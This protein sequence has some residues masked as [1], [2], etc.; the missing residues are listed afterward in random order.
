M[1][2]LSIFFISALAACSPDG[3]ARF[4]VRES[5]EQL[6]VTHATPGQVLTLFDHGG[7]I[8]ASGTADDQGSLMFRKV[9]PADGYVIWS[10]AERSRH[11]SVISVALSQPP[12]S[13]YWQQ[14]LTA[15]LNYIKT[16]DGTTLS[17]YVTLPGPVEMGP[18]PTVVTYS[19]YDPSRPPDMGDNPYA[20][21]CDSIP[22]LCDRPS[23]PS[24]LI[25]AVWGYA[26]V[27]V[28]IR[29]TGCSGGAYDYFE[30]LQLLDGYDV[31]ETVAA[32]EWVQGH[33]VGLVGLSYPGITQLFVA[34]TNPPHLA[35]IT[36]LSVIGNSETT[37]L[38]GGI[39]NDGFAIDWVHY[40]LDGAKPYGQGWE[41]P[42]VDAGDHECA[43]NQL[44]HAQAIDNVQQARTTKFY[45]PALHDRYNPTTFVNKIQVPVF[46]AGAWQDEQTGPFFFTLL[47]KFTSSPTT[48]FHVY[49]GVHPDGFQPTVLSEW[50]SFL[51]LFVADRVPFDDSLQRQLS[52]LLYDQIYKAKVRIPPSRWTN[53][54]NVDAAIA[55]WKAAPTLRA[56][57]ESGAGQASL[58]GAPEPTFVH[59]FAS[60]PPPEQT[61]ERWYLHAD[62]GLQQA[63]PTET[64]AS[65][66][67][68]L[69][70]GAGERGIMAPGGNI[71]D[72]LPAYNW[73]Q[74]QPGKAVVFESAP[75]QSEEV[76]LGPA[77]F[78]LWLTSS[79]VD[80]DLQVNLSEV[81]PDGKE[82]YI[83]SGW[84]RASYRAPSGD[85]TAFYPAPSF[86]EADWQPLVPGQWTQVR[87]GLA[88]FQ[89][90]FRPGSRLRVWIDTPGGT[91]SDWR[92]QWL[93]LS[94]PPT[95][96]IG[97]DAQHSSSVALPLLKGVSAPSPLPPCPSLRGQPCRDWQAF[98]NQ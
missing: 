85:A 97:H 39:L 71:W 98:A 54:P 59:E 91:R 2:G 36:P 14:Q 81:R 42:R 70:P 19:G 46:L 65:S 62:G 12:V 22:A 9:P 3:N 23:D 58:L 53:Y 93:G 56:V 49:N 27:G 83:Q 37:L 28:N 40:V 17:A 61:V 34:S 84:L 73:V 8:V 32:Q 74:P 57:F 15:G 6:H 76:M 43:E 50:R 69:D 89:H 21:L 77:S 75:L 68:Q 55:A 33:K 52:P 48:R 4:T 29:G 88:P 72:L 82:M 67:F 20:F 80:A 86:R 45:D 95:I 13:L 38:P 79:D 26:T 16:R 66:Q 96:V 60:W 47:D 30:D 31:V 63:A 87:V 51:D 18:Y 24:A 78:D 44:L 11:L 41:Q 94:T 10:G 90:V 1:R 25:A 92:F 64:S 35:A 5:V 7:S